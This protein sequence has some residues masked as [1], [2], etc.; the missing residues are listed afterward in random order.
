MTE[1][2]R[3]E[4]PHALSRQSWRYLPEDTEPTNKKREASKKEDDEE[5]AK[6]KPKV[7]EKSEEETPTMFLKGLV[8]K[9]GSPVTEASLKGKIVLLYFSSSWCP[10]CVTFTPMLSVLFEE[11][12]DENFAVIYVSSDDTAEQCQEYY[13]K[14]HADWFCLPFDDVQQRSELKKRYGVFAGKEQEHF[15]DTT[16]KSGI[17]TLVVVDREGASLELLDCDDPKVH[18]EIQFK[19]TDFLKQWESHRWE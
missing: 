2:E 18:K 7:A 15:P 14:K 5:D 13:Q 3:I 9:E 11:V 17:P 12:E 1:Q 10:G 19:G 6:K 16:R 8:D 4:W